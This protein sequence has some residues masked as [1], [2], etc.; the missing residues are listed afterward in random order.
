MS[1]QGSSMGR[2]TAK[3]TEGSSELGG[4]LAKHKRPRSL[5]FTYFYFE[6]PPNPFNPYGFD[7]YF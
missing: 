7:N 4:D 1:R 2:L 3:G 6:T 5:Q